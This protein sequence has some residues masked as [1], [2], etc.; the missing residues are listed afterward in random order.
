MSLVRWQ[1]FREIDTMQR[2]MNRI[3]DS[4]VPVSEGIFDGKGF[5][6]AVEIDE[7]DE[8]VLLKLELPGLNP[9]D[10]DIQVTADSVSIAGERKYEKTTEEKGMTRSEFRYGSFQRVIPL[11]ARVKNTEST[12]DYK[13]GIL[14]LTLPKAEEEKSKVFKLSLTPD[15]E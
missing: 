3:F 11:P 14:H 6:P 4:L 8:A 7:T 12:A 10:L 9:D 5:A 2:E 13:D 1:P 15:S